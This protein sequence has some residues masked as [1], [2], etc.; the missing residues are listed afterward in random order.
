MSSSSTAGIYVA[1]YEDDGAYKHWRLFVDGPT[2]HEKKILQVMGSSQRYYLDPLNIDAR[3]LPQLL[4]MIHICD[5]PTAKIESIEKAG[6]EAV[7]HNEFPGYN[8]Q[9]YVLELLDELEARQIINGGDANYKRQLDI[10]K[11][12]Q[13]GLE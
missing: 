2:Q 9:D 13:E 3:D 1:L 4:E 5:V 10:M 6:A 11:R 8:C 7:V 12:K